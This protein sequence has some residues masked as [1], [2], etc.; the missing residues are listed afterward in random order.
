[1]DNLKNLEI[2]MV[3]LH[4]EYKDDIE[5]LRSE[6]RI[7][8]EKINSDFYKLSNKIMIVVFTWLISFFIALI[9][10]L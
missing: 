4:N 9:R 8:F 7:N 3:K 6:D 1:S 2:K 10:F 5:K